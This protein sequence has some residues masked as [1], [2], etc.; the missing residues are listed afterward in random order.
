MGSGRFAKEE[1]RSGTVGPCYGWG[2]SCVD[3]NA[4]GRS[5]TGILR[6]CYAGTRSSFAKALRT[7]ILL[8]RQAYRRK[9][10]IKACQGEGPG[11]V[12]FLIVAMDY[13]TKWIEAK[14]VATITGNQHFGL[15]K[16][17]DKRTGRKSKPEFGGGNKSKAEKRQQELDGR[18]FSCPFSCT[19]T[20]WSNLVR[21]TLRPPGTYGTES[22][23]SRRRSAKCH[24][25]GIARIRHWPKM[26][27]AL[28]INL[29]LLEEKW[30]ES[31]HN[32]GKEQ[33][34]NGKILQ[35]QSSKHKL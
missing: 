4:G 21:R 24:I 12:K 27:E 10:T 28:Q 11:K 3:G 16:D 22:L 8:V 7:G 34:T 35:C 20:I 18:N 15:R 29:E 23:S 25:S 9:G 33:E 13:F 6:A 31:S 17:P 1:E 19:P 5:D 2:Q 26:I 14:P 30:R 32:R